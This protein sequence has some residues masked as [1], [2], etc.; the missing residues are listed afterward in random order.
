MTAASS[1]HLT[2]TAD[3]SKPSVFEILSHQGFA[4]A[5][6]PAAFHII[7]VIVERNP[8]G[9][10]ALAYQYFD[11][12]YL[13]FDAVVQWHY[14]LTRGATLSETFYG[15]ERKLTTTNQKL[16][17]LRLS[18]VASVILPYV[19]SKLERLYKDQLEETS[20]EGHNSQTTQNAR[21]SSNFLAIYPYFKAMLRAVN[22]YYLLSFTF[23][24]S[25]HHSLT[26]RLLQMR[27]GYMSQD[28]SK[29]MEAKNAELWMTSHWKNPRMVPQL[30]L[31]GLGESVLYAVEMGTFFIQ[32]LEWW[33]NDDRRARVTIASVPV[34]PA[35]HSAHT[36][37][38][39]D[40][41]NIV[42]LR[43]ED[44]DKCPL[45]R[46]Q[47]KNPTAISVSGMVYCYG[48]ILPYLRKESMCPLTKL[49]CNSNHLIRI[50]QS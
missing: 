17:R 5:L 38:N 40:V 43:P 1:A 26:F 48:C 24:Y 50:Y 18:Y 22:L 36:A 19:S 14:I 35:P 23:G 15:L 39:K 46:K 6:K 32:F 2:G 49:V 10:C 12:L 25:D 9:K 21:V 4:K 7:K 34:P 29:F 41:Q 20:T 42:K 11:E 16:T 13:M 33:Y 37:E 27:L 3:S 30:V 44:M 31:R 8:E 47:L 45:C 28:R